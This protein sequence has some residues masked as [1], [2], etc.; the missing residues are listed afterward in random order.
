M[1]VRIVARESTCIGAGQ[2][3]FADPDT[4]DQ[5]DHGTVQILRPV[6][7]TAAQ[8]AAAKQAINICPSRSLSLE[9]TG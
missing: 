9:E 3:V 2:C 1:S 4:F 6:P 8:L 5:N 7:E